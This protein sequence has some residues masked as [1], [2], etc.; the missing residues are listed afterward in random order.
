MKNYKE[1]LFDDQMENTQNDFL[2]SLENFKKA[3]KELGL[4]GK[5]ELEPFVKELEKELKIVETKFDNCLSVYEDKMKAERKNIEKLIT[6]IE[7]KQAEMQRKTQY[8]NAQLPQLRKVYTMTEIEEP[9]RRKIQN[10][11]IDRELELISDISSSIDGLLK[12]LKSIQI[13]EAFLNAKKNFKEDTRVFADELLVA[14]EQIKVF[15]LAFAVGKGIYDDIQSMNQT[16]P[17]PPNQGNKQNK[18]FASMNGN[19][20]SLSAH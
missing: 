9:Q 1:N 3:G 10:S 12:E 18:H 11:C 5:T 16:L 14:R 6:T 7:E 19:G 20:P 2:I 17:P 13:N 8:L 15:Q 4:S